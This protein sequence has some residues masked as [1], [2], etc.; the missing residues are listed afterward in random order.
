MLTGFQTKEIHFK[1]NINTMA[2]GNKNIV[3]EIVD[4]VDEFYKND[5]SNE[6]KNEKNTEENENTRRE[7]DRHEALSDDDI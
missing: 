4:D 6:N 1:T 5:K 2:P 3:F 7:Y